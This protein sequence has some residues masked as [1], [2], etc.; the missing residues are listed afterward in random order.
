MLW[1]ALQQLFKT[2]AL[3][4][5]QVKHEEHPGFATQAGLM[6]RDLPALLAYRS[7]KLR[8][9]T[10]KAAVLEPEIRAF[11]K[12]LLEGK[13]GTTEI[14]VSTQLSYPGSLDIAHTSTALKI[15]QDT[16]GA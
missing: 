2:A 12:R 9:A 3:I 7:S 15:A 10:L 4:L 13:A 6:E 1:P 14:Q 5:A 11:L 16:L 8:L